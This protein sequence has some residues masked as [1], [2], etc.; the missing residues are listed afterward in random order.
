MTPLNPN[1]PPIK[2]FVIRSS[3]LT[4]RQKNA[5][6]TQGHYQLN[7]K[8]LMES[9]E[10]IFGRAAPTIVDIGFGMGTSLITLAK[11]HPD[12][13]FVGI[14]VYQPGIGNVLAEIDEQGIKNI[15]IFCADAVEVVKHLKDASLD[16][17][18][19]FF[20]DPWHKR[21]HHKRRLIQT[22]F[23]QLIAAKLKSGGK[24]HLA[25]DWEDYA[26]HMLKILSNIKE[27]LNTAPD[28]KF[29]THSGARPL[30]KYEARG[31][32]LGHSVWDLVFVMK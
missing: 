17:V 13:H 32:L 25:T 20:P 5:L 4:K 8:N 3:R 27:L 31:Q 11:S 22:E 28:G 26:L 19:I 6:D 15:R 2:S 29:S 1:H 7:H 23:I 21:R 10:E 24:L 16:G 30:T 18:H 12:L 9:W 14:E